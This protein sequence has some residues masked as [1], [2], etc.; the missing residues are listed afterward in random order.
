MKYRLSERDRRYVEQIIAEI[1]RRLK[2]YRFPSDYREIGWVGFLEIF[3]A[4]REKFLGTGREGWAQAAR[5]IYERLYAEKQAEDIL[6]YQTISLDEPISPEN[7]TP[8]GEYL[9]PKHGDFQSSVCFWD[10]LADL[11]RASH[12]AGL[13]ARALANGDTLREVQRDNGWKACRTNTAFRETRRAMEEYLR[14]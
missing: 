5:V 4:H 13:L 2:L 11:D 9:L 14:I 6:K 1:C 8:R 12:D 3:R 7:D 10:Y